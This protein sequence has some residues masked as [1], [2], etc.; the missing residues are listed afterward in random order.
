[1]TAAD[2]SVTAW[3]LEGDPAVRWQVMRDLLSDPGEAVA[4]ERERV[5]TAGLG[6]ELLSHQ[7]PEGTWARGLYN[8]KW[9]STFYTLLLLRSLGLAP[10]NEAARRGAAILLDRGT[11]FD[12]GL[13]YNV[14]R[15]HREPGET[16]VTGMGLAICSYFG[17]PAERLQ[18]LIE[19]LL[20]EQMPD[21]GWNCRR[22]NGATHSSFHT[23]ISALDGL[24]DWE[25]RA[26]VAGDRRVR[27]A[28]E[29]AHE[30]LL[31]HSL[32]R[33]H[34]TGRVAH[35]SFTRFPFPTHWHYDALRGLDYLR[36]SG[37]S[38]DPRIAPAIN[39]VE[40]RRLADG[41]WPAHAQHPGAT[42]VQFEPPREPGRWT[43]L[44]ALRVLDWWYGATR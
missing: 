44:R 2:G 27:D 10:G 31:A 22:P 11:M 33:S 35:P 25:R 7:D 21:G 41:R 30:F 8:P 28:R 1:M 29:R 34:T 12:G 38:P 3:L 14:P 37:V 18:P 15:G 6:A 9:T 19:N 5:A 24:L 23:T 13:R 16:C 26:D 17:Q 4:R 43:T 36:A 20:H 32:Y 40:S 42:W 39:L